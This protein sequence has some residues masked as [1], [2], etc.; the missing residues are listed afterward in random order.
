MNLLAIESSTEQCSVAL[1][2][3]GQTQQLVSDQPRGH[4]EQ[5]LPMIETL[6]ADSGIS[7]RQIDQVVFGQGPGSFTGVRIACSVA[8]GACRPRPLPA[9]AALWH[10]DGRRVVAV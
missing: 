6:L 8:H 4:A 2:C 9:S 10:P 3:G 1:R 7:R 5:I